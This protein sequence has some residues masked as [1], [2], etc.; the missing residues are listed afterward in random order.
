MQETKLIINDI[1]FFK[2][3][4]NSLSLLKHLTFKITQTNFYILSVDINRYFI[5]LPEKFYKIE[6][7]FEFTVITAQLLEGLNLISTRSS[8]TLSNSLKIEFCLSSGRA[9]VEISFI[10]FID[11]EYEDISDVSTKFIIKRTNFNIPF[12][13]IVNYSYKKDNLILRRDANE[14]S[15]EVQVFEVNFIE[16]RNLNFT[17]S[18]TWTNVYNLLG[19]EIEDVLFNFCDNFMSVQ[20]LFKKY[21]ESFFEIQ[22]PRSL[23]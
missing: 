16:N 7:D 8:F 23:I 9:K 11:H 17:C 18:N 14:I 10:S 6:R 13:G 4:I 21:D 15:E 3:L 2:T 12:T 1:L 19:E 20:F 22:V 5:S